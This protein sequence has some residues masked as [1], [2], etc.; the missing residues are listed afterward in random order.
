MPRKAK[1]ETQRLNEGCQSAP[2]AVKYRFRPQQTASTRRQQTAHKP[3]HHTAQNAPRAHEKWRPTCYAS[4]RAEP[5]SASWSGT[6][7]KPRRRPH[8]RPRRRRRT[9]FTRRTSRSSRTTTVGAEATPRTLL[10][11]TASSG[12]KTARRKKL[13]RNRQRHNRRP[14][15]WTPATPSRCA[16]SC[17]KAASRAPS[18]RSW[19]SRAGGEASRSESPM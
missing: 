19:R 2:G 14:R 7:P 13:R 15:P 1:R 4:P 12:T 16:A 3:H 8:R 9:A 10:I 17:A 11:T 18:R 5:A 6:R